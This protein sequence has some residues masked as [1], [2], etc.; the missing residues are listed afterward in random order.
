MFVKCVMERILLSYIFWLSNTDQ[1]NR[2]RM[3]TSISSRAIKFSRNFQKKINDMK[4]MN[5]CTELNSSSLNSFINGIE[6]T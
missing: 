1:Y 5:R 6:K 3:M 2:A 4:C